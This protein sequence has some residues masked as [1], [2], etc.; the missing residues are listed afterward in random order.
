M[1]SWRTIGNHQNT[2]H[3]TVWC[4]IENHQYTVHCTV[5]G[6]IENHQYSVHCTVWCTIENHKNTVQY[7]QS[8]VQLKITKI[9]YTTQSDN[10]MM[11]NIEY[12]LRRNNGKGPMGE[13]QEKLFTFI[14]YIFC[15]L[16]FVYSYIFINTILSFI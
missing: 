2:V 9:R 6:T 4:T 5:W 14:L 16:K 3:Y 7:I 1:Y 12:V 8:D 10:I 15:C 11:L 13:T